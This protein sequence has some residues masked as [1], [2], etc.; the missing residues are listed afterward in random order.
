M[1]DSGLYLWYLDLLLDVYGVGGPAGGGGDGRPRPVQAVAAP[2]PA[3]AQ[4]QAG[5]AGLGGVA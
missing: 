5:V 4:P 2:A 1:R 3:R